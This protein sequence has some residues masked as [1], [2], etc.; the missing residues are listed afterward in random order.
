MRLSLLFGFLGSGKT[1]LARR[2]LERRTKSRKMA[3]IVNEFGDVG[4]DGA[5]LQGDAVDVVELTSGCLC[6]TLKGPLLSA[7]EELAE[8]VKPHQIVVEATGVAE[9]EE[10]IETFSDSS[11]RG[12]YDIG[13]LVTVVDA[14]NYGKLQDILG[15]FYSDQIAHSDIV[16]L[17]KIDLCSAAHLQVV[18]QEVERLNPDATVYFAERCDIDVNEV[19]NG[20]SSRVVGDRAGTAGAEGPH[21]GSRGGHEPHHASAQSFVLDASGGA[22]R[23]AIEAFFGALPE[24][25][26]RAKGFMT[27]DAKSTLVQYSSSGLEISSSE[28]RDH[29]YLVFIG[30]NIDR[31]AIERRLSAALTGSGRS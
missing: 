17:N 22:G 16:V 8:R 6:C 1:T 31:R 3:V 23:A 20:P 30:P 9:P 5:I 24:N 14:A 25:I 4:I 26:W 12:R 13:P 21:G 19:L 10:M 15:D 29:E 11:F 2:I 27:I 18:Q 28:H 7:I